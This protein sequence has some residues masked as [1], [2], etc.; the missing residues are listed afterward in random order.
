MLEICGGWAFRVKSLEAYDGLLRRSD[1]LIPEEDLDWIER[2]G[3]KD[4]R[5]WHLA[6]GF[7]RLA[8]ALKQD[9]DDQEER[10][11][12]FGKTSL[13]ARRTPEV[14]EYEA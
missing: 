7:L 11:K 12:S 1:S 9:H 4:S 8:Q 10:L 3:R 6:N 2:Q 13:P 14:S 5:D